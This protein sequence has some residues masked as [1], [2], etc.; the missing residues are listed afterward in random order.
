MYMTGQ[1]NE[2]TSQDSR[3]TSVYLCIEICA[4]A[5]DIAFKFA[6]GAQGHALRVLVLD[7]LARAG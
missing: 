3:V 1:L 7:T 6:A 4:L 5:L 2:L